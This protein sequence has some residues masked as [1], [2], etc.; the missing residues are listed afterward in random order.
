MNNL[1]VVDI[2]ADSEGFGA[3]WVVVDEDAAVGVIE[4]T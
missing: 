4:L 3:R 2:D 1:K